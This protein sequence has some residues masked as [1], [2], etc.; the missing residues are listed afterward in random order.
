MKGLK[1]V[2]IGGGSS[3]TPELID[4]FIKRH[5]QLPAAEIWLVDIPA[6]EEKLKIVGAL[7]KRMVTKAN[8]AIEI[9]MT[10]D[11]AAALEGADFVITQ[12]RVGGLDARNRDERFP[13]AYDVI[14]QETTGP[15]GMAKA[16]RTIPIM[17]ELCKDMERICPH[18]WL[19]NFTNPAGLVT[20]AVLKHTKVKCIGLCNVP[21]NMLMTTAKM[22]EADSKDLYIDFV[23]LNHL[24]WGRKIWLK[25]EDVTTRVLEILLDGHS[26]NMK[27]IHDLQWSRSFIEA[28]GMLPCPYHRYYYM[29]DAMVLEEQKALQDGKGTR[30][31]QVKEVEQRLFELYKDPELA[32]KPQELEKRG[33]AYYS[34]AAVSLIDAIYNNKHEIHTVNTMNNG[35]IKELP[36]NSVIEVNCMIDRKG[37]T[38]LGIGASLPPEILGL[39]QKVK[40]YELLAIEAAVYGDRKKALLA[41]ATH[42]LIPSVEVAEKLLEDML[43]INKEYLPQF[44]GGC[45][46]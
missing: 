2:V 41:L 34:E 35:T 40:C 11:R 22:L 3:Y 4:G 21:I 8:A 38:P 18:A 5:Q 36:D 16:L 14:G 15:G 46:A 37:A 28:L 20:E 1:I 12:F 23:G 31:E 43:S 44:E 27:N 7:A 45:H 33:G 25:G 24:I 9:M 39:V 26:L 29:T 17:L 32:E 13:L 30:A 42:P 6:G 19:I 10:L